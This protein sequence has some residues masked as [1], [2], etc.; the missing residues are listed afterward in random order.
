M[1]EKRI[2]RE[3]EENE[4]N[5]LVKKAQNLVNSHYDIQKEYLMGEE[6]S[7]LKGLEEFKEELSKHIAVEKMD[8]TEIY[9]MAQ[10]IVMQYLRKGL[11]KKQPSSN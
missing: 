7:E 4:I 2:L 9:K 11:P 5:E 8:H 3:V 6:K 10:K 1:E